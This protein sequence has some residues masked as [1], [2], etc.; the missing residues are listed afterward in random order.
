MAEQIMSG[1]LDIGTMFIASARD[2]EDGINLTLNSVRDCFRDI[3]YAAEFEEAL[4]NQGASFIRDGNKLYVLGND[5]YNLAGMTEFVQSQTG[6]NSE[7]LK[8]PMKDGILNPDSPKLAMTVLRELMKSC[9]EKDIGPARSGEVLYFSVPANPVDSPIDNTFHAKT[10][11]R[12]LSNLGY[13]A[14]PLS[15]GLAVILSENPKMYTPEGDVPFSGIGASFGAGMVNFCLAQ[16]GVAIDEFSVAR[17]GDWLDTQTA[18]MTGQPKTKVMRTKE[19]KLDFNKIDEDD[20]VILALDCYY[21]EMVRHVFKHFSDRFAKNK[22]KLEHPIDIVLSGGTASPKGFDKKV[23]SVIST[24]NLPF[25]IKE[26]RLAKNM[27]NTVAMGCYMRAK[28]AAKKLM[29]EKSGS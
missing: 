5:A 29:A 19:K 10:A 20:E 16:R 18:R 24:M 17:S 26:I 21:E 2:A 22:G 4:R 13:D 7:I 23:R 27:L 1:G 3:E 25:E 12:F 15:E 28:Q 6:D 8:R 11:Q 9:L 14:R